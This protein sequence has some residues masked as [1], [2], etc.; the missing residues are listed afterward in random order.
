M[1]TRHRGRQARI[2]KTELGTFIHQRLEALNMTRTELGK[3][4]GVSAST[5][6][7]MLHGDTK[8]IQRVTPE[9]ISN[10]LELD[11][12]NRR[13]FLKIAG[14]AGFA[15]T[16]GAVAP[17]VIVRRT[18]D[19]D[20]ADHQAKFLQY[21]LDQGCYRQELMVSTQLWYDKLMEQDPNTKDLRLAQAQVR[22]GVILGSIQYFSLPWYQRPRAV[23]VF[24]MVENII[25]RFAMEDIHLKDKLVPIQKEY[26][27]LL[28]LR[29]P[30]YRD[31]SQRPPPDEVRISDNAYLSRSNADY[32]MGI[33]YAQR[34]NDPLLLS[35][36]LRHRFHNSAI[37][38]SEKLWEYQIEEAREQSQYISTD[39][40][41]GILALINDEKA[42][43]YKRLAFNINK[44]FSRR[45]RREYAERALQGLEESLAEIKRFPKAEDLLMQVTIERSLIAQSLLV[46]VDQAQC[47]ILIEPK[48]AIHLIE[49]IWHDIEKSYPA[50]LQKMKRTLHFAQE[51][52]YTP[53]SN[54][55]LLFVHDRR[56]R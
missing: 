39:Y 21:M 46:K 41:E 48:E 35:I 45:T 53:N 24:N 43:G 44:E 20:L 34:V 29:A 9:S 33:F 51:Q 42:E 54:P 2:P 56:S 38:G 31:F 36:L 26:A 50:L 30:L 10:A 12:V 15:L 14:T 18:I 1:P 13:A 6:G 4:L 55:L 23:R 27:T 22:F 40:R 25:S 7:R 19:L 17:K 28:S 52:L 49:Q 37:L 47:L 5:I 11:D 8:V 3:R 16:T 32:D